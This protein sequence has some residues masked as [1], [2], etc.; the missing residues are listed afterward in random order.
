MV[1]LNQR[2][3]NC[4][5]CQ[6]GLK[7]LDKFCR[8]CGVKQATPECG[9]SRV[10]A[11][12]HNETGA[13]AEALT[14]GLDEVLTLPAARDTNVLSRP[15]SRPLLQALAQGIELGTILKGHGKT[16]RSIVTALMSAPVWL[17]IILLSPFDAWT[18]TKAM[19][20]QI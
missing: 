6:A 11:G 2:Q 12:L 17:M 19:T 3:R 7:L 9:M 16:T 15:V 5:A 14:K 20:K 10:T 13:C 1:E 18:T 4:T 8:Q